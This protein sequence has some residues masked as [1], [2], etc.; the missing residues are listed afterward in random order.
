MGAL[1]NASQHGQMAMREVL[2]DFLKRIKR[3]AQGFPKKLYPFTRNANI[4][5]HPVSIEI[6]PVVSFGRPVLIGTSIRTEILVERFLAGES[7]AE[8]AKDYG[9]EEKDIEEAI[10]YEKLVA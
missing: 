3:D 2:K 10:R 8:L 4:R 5:E 6:N 7:T 1:I 9:R